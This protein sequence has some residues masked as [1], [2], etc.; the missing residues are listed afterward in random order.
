MANEG[1]N[2]I[3]DW[4]VEFTVEGDHKKITDTVGSGPM[5]MVDFNHLKYKK[6]SVKKNKITYWPQDNE[7]LIQK[8]KRFFKAYIIPLGKSYTIPIKWEILARDYNHSGLINLVVEPDYEEIVNTIYVE[9]EQELRDDFILSIKEK[10]NYEDEKE[11]MT[12]E[13]D[14]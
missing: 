11:G 1:L 10:K 12:K 9:T 5:G 2:V 4:R 6:T 8:D 7:P 13:D 3:E 14:D